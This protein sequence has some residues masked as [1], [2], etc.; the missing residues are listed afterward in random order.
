MSY[1]KKVYVLFPFDDEG[2]IAGAYVGSSE[3]VN[4]RLRIH[5]NTHEGHGKQDQLHELM[6]KNG[7]TYA[8]VDEIK[9][10][11]ETYIEFDWIDFFQK[12]T[13]L[14]VFNNFVSKKANWER[15][16]PKEVTA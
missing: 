5:K 4:E 8:V 3:N 15:I 16:S 12:R 7:Y 13:K 11:H 14:A 2:L 1:P 10:F 6:R 9:S